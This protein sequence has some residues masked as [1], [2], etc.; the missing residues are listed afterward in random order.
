MHSLPNDGMPHQC[1]PGLDP[2]R[3]V[4][5]LLEV[6]FRLLDPKAGP[7]FSCAQEECIRTPPAVCS[8]RSTD[9]S[10]RALGI[11]DRER[12][13]VEY[14]GRG[15][16]G[17]LQDREILSCAKENKIRTAY[18]NFF[19]C[20]IQLLLVASDNRNV[21]TTSGKAHRSTKPHACGTPSDKTML[22]LPRMMKCL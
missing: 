17:R 9:R 12:V 1:R 4:H 13:R 14:L 16:S 21:C 7:C 2:V 3:F 8:S 5:V 20:A 15:L 19:Q 10:F 6:V 11:I 22:V 18:F